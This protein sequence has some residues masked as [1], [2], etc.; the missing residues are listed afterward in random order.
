MTMLI[1]AM[2]IGC[3]VFLINN[4]NLRDTHQQSLE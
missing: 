2:A 3:Y 4:S 1:L